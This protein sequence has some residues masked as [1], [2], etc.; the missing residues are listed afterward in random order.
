MQRVLLARKPLHEKLKALHVC[1]KPCLSL[2]VYVYLSNE[3]D[4]KN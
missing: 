4:Y 3:R 2:D 1:K